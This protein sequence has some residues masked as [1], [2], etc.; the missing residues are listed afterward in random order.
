MILVDAN[1]LIFAY[2]KKNEAH[3]KARGWLEE[4]LNDSALVGLP[5]QCLLAFLRVV[6][7]PRV[8]E[9][10]ESIEN[11]WLQV[12]QWLDCE[13]AWIPQPTTRHAK[14]LG[15][16]LSQSDAHGNLVSDAHLAALAIE[17]GLTLCST[18]RDFAQFEGLRW[19]NPLLS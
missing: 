8:F 5:W 12:S 18:D 16:L 6:T 3:E 9:S 15:S 13:V 7:N 17:H 2:V 19:E 1:I 11:A 10:P 4:R 14:I